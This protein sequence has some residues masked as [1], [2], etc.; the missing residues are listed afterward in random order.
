MGRRGSWIIGRSHGGRQRRIERTIWA[1]VWL[2]LIV[3]AAALVTGIIDKPQRPIMSEPV[4]S[5]VE[6]RKAAFREKQG[7]PPPAPT[8]PQTQVPPAVAETT[9]GPPPVGA[10]DQDPLQQPATEASP[11]TSPDLRTAPPPETAPPSSSDDRPRAHPQD[12]KLA[13]PAS[14]GIEHDETMSVAAA[15]AGPP[16]AAAAPPSAAGTPPAQA[17]ATAPAVTRQL[18]AIVASPSAPAVSP[19]PAATALEPATIAPL[20]PSADAHGP[21]L[22]IIID[23]VGPAAVASRTAIDLPVAVTL[24]FLPYF[25]RDAG[26]CRGGGAARA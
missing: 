3:A 12:V 14:P 21:A 4:R 9:P 13:P 25:R 8:V 15:D 22:A 18:S 19:L 11:P 1:A 17:P 20:P 16:A 24:S 6:Q 5:A 7:L 26:A 23:D 2:G 10:R